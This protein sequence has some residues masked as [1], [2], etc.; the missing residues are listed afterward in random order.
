MTPVPQQ[1]SLDQ[2]HWLVL[3]IEIS[4]G[5][6]IINK[7]DQYDTQ[8]RCAIP[9]YCGPGKWDSSRVQK[10][11]TA[12]RFIECARTKWVRKGRHPLCCRG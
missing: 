10:L 1:P 6:I 8:L 5:N 4:T 2:K 9:C 12:C 11:I 7:Y 3:Q